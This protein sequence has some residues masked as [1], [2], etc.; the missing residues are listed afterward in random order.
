MNVA[1]FGK[2]EKTDSSRS[3]GV[4]YMWHYLLS[5]GKSSGTNK[6]IHLRVLDEKKSI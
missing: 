6:S 2:W 3:I 1:S 4:V 5:H